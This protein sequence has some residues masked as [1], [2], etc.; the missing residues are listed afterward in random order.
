MTRMKLVHRDTLSCEPILRRMP[1]GELLLVCQCGDVTEPAP[2]NRVY[3]FHSGDDGNTWSK[4]SLIREDDGRAVYQTE[5]TVIGNKVIVY[6]TLHNGGFVDWTGNRMV[7]TDNG[8]TWT[9][10]GPLPGYET[11]TFPRGAI[12]LR[13]GGLMMAVQHYPVSAQENER[14]RREKRPV[15]DA[16]I[17]RV[18]NNV[19]ISHDE[20]ENWE[21]FCGPIVM[22]KGTTGRKWVWSEPTILELKDGR[23]AMLLRVCGTGHLWRSESVDGGHSFSTPVPASI[24]N[25]N[26]KPKLL[27]LQD[28][29][30][31]L[32][33]TP[34]ST[35]GFGGRNPLAVWISEDEMETFPD[36]RIITDFPGVFCYPDGFCEDDHI[37]FSIEYNRHDI[38]FMDVDLGS[39]TRTASLS[40]F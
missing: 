19:L 8:Y 18:E 24:P 7:S 9:S 40:R 16:D 26:N 37:K 36:R 30:I 28:G 15:F 33:H 14:L 25:P 5:V 20:G 21:A 38:L 1:N 27:R 4:P 22:M 32:I 34:N 12:R 6:L 23:I 3:V 35:L 10:I 13:N 11:F 2:E 31:A 29:R 17:D 39:M